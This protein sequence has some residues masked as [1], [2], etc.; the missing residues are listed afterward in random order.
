MKNLQILGIV[1]SFGI[2]IYC[3]ARYKA[4]RYRKIDLFIGFVI[5][6]G[7]LTISVYPPA[8][9][10]FKN[11]LSMKYRWF[12]TLAISNFILFILFFYLLGLLNNNNRTIGELVRALAKSEYK[13]E[14]ANKEMS[15]GIAIVIPAYD[16]EKNIQNV[17]TKIPDNV[18]GYNVRPIVIVDGTTDRTNEIV[19][20]NEHAVTSHLINR[21]QGDSLR[22]GFEIA[23]EEGVDIVVTMDADGQHRPDELERLI[24]PLVD[25]EADYVMGSRFLG[26]Y[27]DRGGA[28]HLGIII[29]SRLISF[30]TG[31]RITDATNGFRAIWARDI[32]KLKLQEDRFNAPELIIEA[33]KKG[34]RIKEVPVT[35]LSRFEGESKKPRGL[36]YPFGF[37][38]TILK[39]WLR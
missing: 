23:L 10:I 33:A 5:F 7:L 21:G 13:K 25:G 22:T 6:T 28:R 36:K 12:A 32:A 19:K 24:K 16:E 3:Y 20:A 39:T 2:I 1:I 4:Q 17:L 35:I 34:L 29:F 26:S 11:M 14:Y 27:A 18:L 31:I 37:G 15:G 9:D 30:L 8:G 38:M